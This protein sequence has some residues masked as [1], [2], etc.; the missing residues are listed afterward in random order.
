MNFLCGGFLK[1]IV[2]SLVL[3][4]VKVDCLLVRMSLHDVQRDCA[5]SERKSSSN[6][7]LRKIGKEKGRFFTLVRIYVL[8]KKM[9]V[10]MVEQF[11]VRF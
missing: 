1:S 2:R 7:F 11:R 6:S 3:N 8:E 9:Q 10:V 4:Q 5:G